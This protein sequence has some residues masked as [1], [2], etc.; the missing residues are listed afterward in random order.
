MSIYMK[1]KILAHEVGK[2][3]EMLLILKQRPYYLTELSEALK[4]DKS[5]LPKK[6]S[7]LEKAGLI[8]FERRAEAKTERKY[9]ILNPIFI[10]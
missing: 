3:W 2:N 10:Q 4:V 8:W 9:L 7:N 1:A 5:V 6:A